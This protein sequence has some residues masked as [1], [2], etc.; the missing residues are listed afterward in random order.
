LHHVVLERWSRGSSFVH[1]L[2]ARAK[3]LGLLAFLVVLATARTRIDVLAPAYLLLLVAA[4]AAA[5]LPAAGVLRRAAAVLPFVAVFALITFFAGQPGRAAALLAKSYLSALAALLLVATTPVPLLLD[6]FE[7]LGAPRY[8]LMVAQFVY[9]Y[10]FV[11][12]EQAQHMRQ[13]ALCRGGLGF[14]AAAGALASLFARSY[15]RA[16]RI[17]R[18]MVARGFQGHF[19]LL[20]SPR[21]SLRDAAAAA[22][23]CLV[24]AALRFAVER[25]S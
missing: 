5:G 19:P 21:F 2:D 6:A 13:A 4:A 1:A 24:P 25:F 17:H 8:L 16:E 15:A 14:R 3:I 23:A 9:R 20:A 18:S 22:A 11:I 12:S 10:L 7:S